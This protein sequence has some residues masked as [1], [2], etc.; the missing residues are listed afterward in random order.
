MGT[1]GPSAKP[2][3][4]ARAGFRFAVST[5]EYPYMHPQHQGF[6]AFFSFKNGG[7]ITVSTPF[8]PAA[9]SPRFLLSDLPFNQWTELR[10]D[11]GRGIPLAVYVDALGAIGRWL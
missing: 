10:D 8:Y 11:R 5:T 7:E 1:A 2:E 3:D 6:Y 9:D 4:P